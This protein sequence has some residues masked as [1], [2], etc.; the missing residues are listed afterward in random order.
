MHKVP[1]L[2]NPADLA[3]K[4]L[5]RNKIEKCCGLLGYS[6]V[7][8]RSATTPNLYSVSSG[9][10]KWCFP[11]AVRDHGKEFSAGPDPVDKRP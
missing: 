4:R 7:D 3:T 9:S 10:R 6:F 1:G 11:T 2:E 5:T 8:G